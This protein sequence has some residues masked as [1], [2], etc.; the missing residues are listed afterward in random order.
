MTGGVITLPVLR[1]R[2]NVEAKNCRDQLEGFTGSVG[3]FRRGE[4]SQQAASRINIIVHRFINRYR[5][6]QDA[7]RVQQFE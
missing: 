5:I 7:R 2:G 6:I 4:T 1:H 3:S